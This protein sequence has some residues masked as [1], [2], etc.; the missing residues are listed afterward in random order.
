[1]LEHALSA[2]NPTV[3]YQHGYREIVEQLATAKFTAAVLIARLVL[4]RPLSKNLNSHPRARNLDLC[5]RGVTPHRQKRI[6]LKPHE[7][8]I[9]NLNQTSRYHRRFAQSVATLFLQEH[10]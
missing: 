3:A 2:L 4:A 10:L 1:M 7:P 5:D 6:D 8:T 9:E